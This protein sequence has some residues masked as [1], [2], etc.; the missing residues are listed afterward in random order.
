VPKCSIGTKDCAS[1]GKSSTG[2]S[3]SLATCRLAVSFTA[4]S[5]QEVSRACATGDVSRQGKF[6]CGYCGFEPH[7]F[8]PRTRSIRTLHHWRMPETRGNGRYCGIF[9]SR[10]VSACFTTRYYRQVVCLLRFSFGCLDLAE[11]QTRR[12]NLAFASSIHDEPTRLSRLGC[13]WCPSWKVVVIQ[14]PLPER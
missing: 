7:P 6:V 4:V 3:A 5:G 9:M 10:E 12:Y 1:P 13:I 11:E 14:L 2:R 8:G